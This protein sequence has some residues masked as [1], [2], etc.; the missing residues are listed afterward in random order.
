LDALESKGCIERK[1]LMIQESSE[2]HI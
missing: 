2:D 1:N